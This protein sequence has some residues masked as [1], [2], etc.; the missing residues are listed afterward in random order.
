LPGFLGKTYQNGKTVPND[1]KLYQMAIMYIDTPNSHKIYILFP[2]QVPPKY[3]QIGIFGMKINHLATLALTALLHL[4][5]HVLEKYSLICF[6]EAL[7]A[8]DV[9]Y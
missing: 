9:L 6:F 4:C 3:T 7:N 5:P 1:H 2:L 8:W